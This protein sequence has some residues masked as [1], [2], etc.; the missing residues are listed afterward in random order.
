MNRSHLFRSAA[1]VLLIAAL[2]TNFLPGSPTVTAATTGEVVTETN[3]LATTTD[4]TK[5]PDVV[6]PPGVDSL[7]IRAVAQHWQLASADPG[8]ESRYDLDSSGRIDIVDVMLAAAQWNTQGQP[9]MVE[10]ILVPPMGST[11]D[12]QGRV[13]CVA[14]AGHR[15]AVYINALEG[16]WTKPTFANPTVPIAAD[17]TWSADITT[18]PGDPDATRI[19]AFVV[20]LGYV[21]PPMSGGY[22]LPPELLDFPHVLVNRARI[23]Q[24][25]GSTWE[26]KASTIG[27][28]GPGPNYFSYDASDVFVDAQGRLHL[29][30]NYHDGRW[31]STEVINAE[32]LAYGTHTFTLASRVDQLDPWP[33]VGLFTWDTG[34][35]QVAYREIDIEHSRWG[36]PANDNAQFV[37]QPWDTAGHMH[38]FDVQLQSDVSTHRFE[39]LPGEVR[40]ASYRGYASPPTPDDLIEAWTYTASDVPPVGGGHLRI[41]FWLFEGHPPAEPQ[42]V[43]VESVSFTPVNLEVASRP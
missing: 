1:V 20:P 26:V 40:F 13:G 29:R 18:G 15:I 9:P 2:L 22:E 10:F 35:P 12:L 39:W 7:D 5:C 38:R 11:A 21:P 34:A 31:W 43:I 30:I 36:Q 37:I 6:S 32:P 25:S 8:Y 3:L 28:A 17:G 4:P 16:W 24:F 23:I 41:N 33:V 42:E 19:A 14:V 27:V